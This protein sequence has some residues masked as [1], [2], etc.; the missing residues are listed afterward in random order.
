MDH[1]RRPQDSF[2]YIGIP[3]CSQS[4][5]AIIPFYQY[6]SFDDQADAL[7]IAKWN[8]AIGL[9][10]LHIYNHRYCQC[11]GNHCCLHK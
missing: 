7:D 5:N 11:K 1:E 4:K 9:V 8:G 10:T 2:G 3:F 6:N